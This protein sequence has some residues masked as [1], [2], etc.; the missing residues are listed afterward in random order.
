MNIVFRSTSTRGLRA[1]ARYLPQRCY[2]LY[3]QKFSSIGHRSF[4]QNSNRRD[5]RAFKYASIVSRSSFVQLHRNDKFFTVLRATPKKW[6]ERPFIRGEG[7]T[8][9]QDI[10]YIYIYVSMHVSRIDESR[11]LS[12]FFPGHS[13]SP[14]HLPLCTFS[15]LSI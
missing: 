14:L 5:D 9:S 3:N 13:F 2:T 10:Q 12:P 15:T 6:E 11:A 4:C 7:E 1:R 8:S